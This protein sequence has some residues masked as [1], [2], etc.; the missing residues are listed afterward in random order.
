MRL[1]TKTCNSLRMVVSLLR[2]LHLICLARGGGMFSRSG[3]RLFLDVCRL[4]VGTV[5]YISTD[6]S[7]F[8]IRQTLPA[9]ALFLC[10]DMTTEGR[11]S[12]AKG[13]V[14]C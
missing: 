1:A 12:G 9:D 7:S 6:H 8:G 2:S 11:N 3:N 10:C 14:C 4:S 5:Y 13:D